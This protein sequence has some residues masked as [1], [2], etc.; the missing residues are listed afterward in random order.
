MSINF[1]VIGTKPGFD[2]IIWASDFS[3]VK[4]GAKEGEELKTLIE[5]NDEHM[6][7]LYLEA[8]E[9]DRS[10]EFLKIWD[11]GAPK[12]N[13]A[14]AASFFALFALYDDYG[15]DAVRAVVG[16]HGVLTRNSY[17][18]LTAK[19]F[20][21][22]AYDDDER[23]PMVYEGD[24]G[25]EDAAE[26][27]LGVERVERLNARGALKAAMMNM[28]FVSVLAYNNSTYTVIESGECPPRAT[29]EA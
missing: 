4:N 6:W 7:A 8:V 19:K 14:L 12:T 3:E 17:R 29:Y 27:Y 20:M 22:C 21:A 18:S 23:Q 26:A 24:D 15:M 13:V 1:A 9:D 16:L 5:H 10:R 28:P 11:Q 25:L 2:P